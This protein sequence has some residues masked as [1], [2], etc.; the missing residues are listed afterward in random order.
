MAILAS[1]VVGGSSVGLNAHAR[2]L[3]VGIFQDVDAILNSFAGGPNDPNSPV[4]NQNTLNR[5]AEHLDSATEK[6][7]QLA[8]ELDNLRTARQTP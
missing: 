8:T 3:L 5:D 1:A 4:V 6:A 7:Q 2:E